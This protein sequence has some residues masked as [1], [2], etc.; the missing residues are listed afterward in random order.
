MDIQSKVEGILPE[1]IELRRWFHQHPELGQ[2]E[3]NT[4]EKICKILDSWGIDYVRGIAETGVVATIAGDPQGKV[5]G[6]R[7]DIDALPIQEESGLPYASVNAKV[8]HA[9]GHDIHTS[10]L[11]GTAKALTLMKN[12]L[13]GTVKMFFQPAE[14][15]IGGA[16]R[17]IEEGCL[18]NPNVDAVIGLHVN[19]ELTTGQIG[20]KFGTMFAGS[21]M[22]TIRVFGKQ[23]HGASPHDG[24]DPIVISANIIM[25]MQTLAS[26]DIAPVESAIFTVGSI[27]AGTVGNIIPEMVEMKCILRTLDLPTRKFLQGRVKDVAT[28]VANAYRG[29][30]EVDIVES[31]GPLI[32]DDSMVDLVKEAASGVLGKENVMMM[33]VPTMGAEDFSYFALNRKAC[34]YYLGIRNEELG[35]IYPLHSQKFLADED[36][37][38]IGMKV[39]LATV[40]EFLDSRT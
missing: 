21:D 22:I 15:T 13:R 18:D 33:R 32:N 5:I 10:I 6:I 27:H 26:R 19:T 9:C 17:M 36:A 38:A 3:H 34:F 4:Q 31:Y 20:L 25:A 8:M 28:Q 30:A 2:N 16:E 29:R 24:V 14:E 37:I 39:N 40:K 11:L 7:A 12:E 23:T 35:S 1:I